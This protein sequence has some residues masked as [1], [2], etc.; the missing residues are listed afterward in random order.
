MTEAIDQDRL[1]PSTV[2]YRVGVS[3]ITANPALD[4]CRKSMTE[5]VVCMTYK[6]NQSFEGPAVLK[7]EL[8]GIR[9]LNTASVM[10]AL[11]WLSSGRCAQRISS[12]KQ[13]GVYLHLA[14]G[15]CCAAASRIHIPLC[16]KDSNEY[17]SSSLVG[18]IALS[19]CF[20]SSAV[21]ECHE[22]ALGCCLG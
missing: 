10:F 18:V 17:S 16:L 4:A 3:K 21:F 20:A 12:S 11:F 6:A 8:D 1:I 15:I 9:P 22:I 19:P 14:H 5:D 2:T 7:Y 13:A